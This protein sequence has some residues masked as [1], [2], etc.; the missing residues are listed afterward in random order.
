VA[1]ERSGL[2]VPGDAKAV[3]TLSFGPGLGT[4]FLVARNN[5]TTL[6]FRP[7]LSPR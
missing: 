2:V 6:A 3:V 7:V 4:G 1:P 5:A